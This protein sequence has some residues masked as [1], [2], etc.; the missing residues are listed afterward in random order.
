MMPPSLHEQ[1]ADYLAMRR[2]LGFE[3]VD[4]GWWLAEFAHYAEQLGHQ[5]PV[6]TDLAVGWALRTRSG[7]PAQ[8]ARRYAAV[9]AFARH[10]A[11]FDPDSEI[12]PAGLLGSTVRPRTQPH[13][14]SDIEI[15]DLLHQASLLLPRAGL[16][17]VTYVA[18]FSLLAAA[19]LRLSEVCRLEPDDVNLSEGVLTVRESK[20]RKSRLVPLHPTA[21][22]ALST[23]AAQRDRRL[24]PCQSG[25]FF[26]TDRAAVLKPNT[27][28]RTFA[29]LR[30]RLGWT[31]QGRARRPRIHDLRHSFAVR[32]LLA[33]HEEGVDLDRKVLALSTYL[34]HARPSDTYWYLTAVPELMAIAS[35]RFEEFAQ[36]SQAGRP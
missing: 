20:F 15:A 23:Y 10:R 3:L 34:G 1:I 25:G 27:V 18:V 16:R 35:R 29:R 4:A 12:P 7:D 21:T 32:R 2:G 6:T 8:A 5:G 30:E 11:V 36:A 24:G 28:E 33:W 22:A 13:I 14:Y 9:Q 19:G 26:R 31:D 17:P